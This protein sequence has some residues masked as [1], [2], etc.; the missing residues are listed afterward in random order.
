MMK[1][2]LI[3]MRHAKTEEQK[4]GQKDYDR[5]LTER[6]RNDAMLMATILK[7]KGIMPKIIIA[8]SANRTIQTA[9]IVANTLNYEIDKIQLS[10][11]LYM[12][13]S[14]RLANTVEAVDADIESC[15]I[16]AHNPGI[17]EFAFDL[18]RASIS[19]SLPTS[20]LVVYSFLAHTWEDLF[21]VKNKIELFEYPKK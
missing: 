19:S 20:G 3:V 1:R 8:S 16:I 11:T 7:E 4:T 2:T 17:S 14:R 15:L 10:Q 12:S 9:E 18:N 21:M 5:N 6:G 13:D